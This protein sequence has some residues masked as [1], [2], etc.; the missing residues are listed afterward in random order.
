ML[1]PKHRPPYPFYQTHSFANNDCRAVVVV[2][3]PFPNLGSPQVVLKRQ[4]CD[5]R[6]R[7]HAALAAASPSGGGG[8]GLPPA[9]YPVPAA[10]PISGSEWYKQ[11]A[12]RALNQAIGRTV[13]HRH[14]YG[15]MVLLDER[16]ECAPAALKPPLTHRRRIAPAPP[17]RNSEK[18]TLFPL[19][20]R[21]LRHGQPGE[22]VKVGA[23]SGAPPRGHGHA[24]KD[25][26]E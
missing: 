21:R 14:D 20:A 12:F 10:A 17:S 9:A 13:R 7:A 18:A 2:S 22:R 23:A 8:G 19:P 16:C 1:S 6:V 11:Q 5:A 15:A 3:I 4:Y 25:G 24:P 26:R